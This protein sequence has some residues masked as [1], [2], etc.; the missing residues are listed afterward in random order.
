[1]VFYF[2]ALVLA[3]LG[4]AAELTS[5]YFS[6]QRYK[7]RIDYLE[8]MLRIEVVGGSSTGA[9]FPFRV[10][11]DGDPRLV[12]FTLVR[13]TDASTDTLA[14]FIV[15][16]VA[17]GI[18]LVLAIIA[19]S[20]WTMTT[21]RMR[22]RPRMNRHLLQ[23]MMI[24]RA[25]KTREPSRGVYRYVLLY[26]MI[27]TKTKEKQNAKKSLLTRYFNLDEVRSKPVEIESRKST[28]Y[29]I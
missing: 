2:F 8:T 14:L 19:A 15:G 17:A 1:M 25:S 23:A 3:S 7:E 18:A 11:E 28:A 4:C 21:V 5:L 26:G 6:W 24:R 9:I 27:H 20:A 10:G 13:V 29:C 16:T 22:A 12:T